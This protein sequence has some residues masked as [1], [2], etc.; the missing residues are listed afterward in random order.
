MAPEPVSARHLLADAAI[1]TVE[2]RARL[3]A[4]AWRIEL[5]ARAIED[6]GASEEAP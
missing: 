6:S 2:V 4:L 3:S 5:L 1:A